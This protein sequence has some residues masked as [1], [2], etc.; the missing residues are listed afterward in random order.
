MKAKF[1]E[2]DR[3]VESVWNAT[4]SSNSL[5]VVTGDHGMTDVGNH[6][7]DT[8]PETDTAAIFIDTR[9]TR[10]YSERHQTSRAYQ[11]D[12]ATTLSLLL[13]LPI[14]NKSK[15]VVI[16]SLLD[17]LRVP[18]QTK[19]CHYFHNAQQF[20]KID[21]ANDA[22]QHLTRALE[23]HVRALELEQSA[24][25][26][27]THYANYLRQVQ[28]AVL[29]ESG[30]Q[31]NV[32]TLLLGLSSSFIALSCLVSRRLCTLYKRLTLANAVHFPLY[33]VLLLSTS[34]MEEEHNYW[35]FV[36][37]TLATVNFLLECRTL[38]VDHVKKRD[39]KCATSARDSIS[40]FI[41][42]LVAFLTISFLLRVMRVWSVVN[43]PFVASFLLEQRNKNLLSATVI[44]ALV[45]IAA[46]GPARWASKQQAL[47]ASGL[48]LVYM[49]RFV[50]RLHSE[51][52]A[53][54]INLFRALQM[55]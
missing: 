12:I 21:A 15:G 1:A 31:A 32:L 41:T 24:N 20:M 9:L 44:V 17:K 16:T 10:N 27:C 43:E 55:R 35:H 50:N 48:L 46:A 36:A 40:L 30:S 5:I 14:P 29:A 13:G 22:R 19:L 53:M 6:G 26:A 54:L 23:N 47:L 38:A 18:S 49:Y 8:A 25:V 28:R 52:T 39:Q 7:G 45:A 11:V 2:M 37:V 33:S 3:V 42:P 34:F 51:V 4:K